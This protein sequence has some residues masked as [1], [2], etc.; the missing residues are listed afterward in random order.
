MPYFDNAATT[1]PYPEVI[2]AMVRAAQVYG[3]PSAAHSLAQDARKL[4]DEAREKVARLINAEPEEIYFTSGGTEA[5]NLILRGAPVDTIYTSAIEH[6]AVLHTMEAILD[7]DQYMTW[8]KLAVDQ[9]GLLIMNELKDLQPKS[10]VSVML[11]NNE[12][13]T[14]QNVRWVCELAHARDCWVHTDAV[15]AAGHI[16]IDVKALGVDYLSISAHKLYGPK[17]IGCL[18]VRKGAPKPAALITGGAQEDG[19]RAGTENVPGIVGFGV[20]AEM[21]LNYLREEMCRLEVLRSRI[22]DQLKDIGAVVNGCPDSHLPGIVNLRFPGIPGDALVLQLDQEGYQ[23]ST[24]SACTTGDLDPSHVLT[25]MGLSGF[26]ADESI[27]ISLG[28]WNGPEQVDL[29]IE[30]IKKNVEKIRKNFEKMSD[31][32]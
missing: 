1:R 27:R 15:Q 30:A 5:D 10:L 23:I 14:I 19:L 22:I 8:H 12:V 20:A 26:E 32:A 3:N 31:N 25:A 21:S 11:A 13:G 4:V 28:Y 18:F 7:T 16:P 17:G 24:G 2:E 9:H 29:L 6:H